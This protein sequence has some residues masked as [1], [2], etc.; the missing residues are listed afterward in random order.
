MANH[1]QKGIVS[2]FKQT[3][4]AVA[5][6]GS[7]DSESQLYPIVVTYYAQD[8]RL[9]ESKD[10]QLQGQPTGRNIGKLIT[11]ALASFYIPVCLA[12]CSDNANV[13]LGKKNRVAAVLTE[14][15]ENIIKIRCPCYFVNLSFHFISFILP[16]IAHSFTEGSGVQK[17]KL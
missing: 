13:M 5:T 9:V 8:T 3:V 16:S 10:K 2:A 4:F 17:K 11:D 6:D 7:N 14:L 12:F 1:F 15:H